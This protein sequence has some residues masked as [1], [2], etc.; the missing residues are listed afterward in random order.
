PTRLAQRTS[1]FPSPQ[2]GPLYVLSVRGAAVLG[3]SNVSTAKGP[4]PFQLSP[5]LKP[6]A[7]GDGRSPLNMYSPLGRGRIL[8]CRS[9]K[10][11]AVSARRT[12]QTVQPAADCS[13]PMNLNVGQAFQPAGLPDFPVRWSK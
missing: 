13:L 2:P 11:S 6:A 5:A 7:P 9:A 4:E 3:S 8:R 12:S 10:P 1:P